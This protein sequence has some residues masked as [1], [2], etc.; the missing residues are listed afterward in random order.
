[1]KLLFICLLIVLSVLLSCSKEGST[2]KMQYPCGS[3]TGKFSAFHLT[4][5]FY[6]VLDRVDTFQVGLLQYQAYNE[7]DYYCPPAGVTKCNFVVSK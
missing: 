3:I 6:I 5:D 4:N 2:E 7:G 1:M